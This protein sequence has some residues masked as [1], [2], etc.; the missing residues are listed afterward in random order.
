MKF[1][2]LI[3]PS[4]LAYLI[5]A[6]VFNDFSFLIINVGSL[7]INIKSYIIILIGLLLTLPNLSSNG[8]IKKSYILLFIIFAS[9][10]IAF[11]MAYMN[12]VKNYSGLLF[13]TLL[14]GLI[15][16]SNKRGNRSI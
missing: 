14:F 1:F 6:I 12:S 16:L 9:M 4:I 7:W 5:I 8:I 13:L 11:F 15:V 3:L 2:K 10:S